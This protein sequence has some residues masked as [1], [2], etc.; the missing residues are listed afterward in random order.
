MK[1]LLTGDEGYIGSA[2]KQHIIHSYKGE[3]FCIDNKYEEDSNLLT[4][5]KWPEVDLV[6]HLAGLSGV[7]DSVSKPAEYWN[8]NV[9]ASRR[10]FNAYSDTRIIYAS[11]SS[12]LEPDLNPYAASKFMLEELASR[13]PYTLGLRFHNVYSETP[14]SGMFTDKLLNNKLEFVTTHYRDFVHLTDVI[15]AIDTVIQYEPEQTVIDVGSGN[16]I[17]LSSLCPVLPIKMSTPYEREYTC[18]NIDELLTLGW[19]PKYDYID[20]LKSYDLL[21]ADNSVIMYS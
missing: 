21:N 15:D 20:F 11:S 2:L 17:K 5:E 12:A 10:L 13:H 1:I 16:P 7:L 19:E 14:R 4:V 8:N 6:I 3:L 18:A 9:E